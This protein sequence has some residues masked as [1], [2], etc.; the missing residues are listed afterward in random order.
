MDV[1]HGGYEEEG[2]VLRVDKD[3][4]ADG[5]GDDV[6]VGMV[7][8]DVLLDPLL[9]EGRGF[10]GGGEELVGEVDGDLDVGFGEGFEDGWVGVVEL[11][12]GDGLGF[13]EVDDFDGGRE[14]VG[15]PA[16]VNADG[17]SFCKCGTRECTKQS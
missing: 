8:G 12:P 3:L 11:D 15:D 13:E 17:A 5:D 9:G 1:L 7:G 16:V 10:G 14:V 4:V 6:G 2:G